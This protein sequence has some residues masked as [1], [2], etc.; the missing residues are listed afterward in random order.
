MSI[1]MNKEMTKRDTR[2]SVENNKMKKKGD[3]VVVVGGGNLNG[4]DTY[5]LFERS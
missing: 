5:E 3:G 1:Y 4:F 2:T